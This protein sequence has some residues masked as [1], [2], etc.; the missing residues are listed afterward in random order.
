MNNNR[1]Q[2]ILLSSGTNEVEFLL[3]KLGNQRYGINVSKVCTIQV[4]ERD[5][6]FP[7]PNQLKEV[8][9]VCIF[10]D[11]TISIIDLALCVAA[12]SD[13]ESKR[14]LL[15]VAE[16]NK[17]ITGFVVDEV[18]RIERFSWTQFEPISETTCNNDVSSV[19]GTVKVN[20]EL[21]IILD[22]ETVVA[23][24]N[25]T[26]SIEHYE[27]NIEK[28]IVDRNSLKIAHIDDS[29]M[30]Q[31]FLAKA[32]DSAGFSSLKQFNN[33]EDAVKFLSSNKDVDLIICDIE[34]PRM[35]G[36]S[37]CK[38]IRK[39]PDFE[40]V[41]I[42]FFSSLITEQM[43]V[44]CKNVGGTASFSK[45]QVDELVKEIDRYVEPASKD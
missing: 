14:R 29:V 36:L 13:S 7:M 17:R 28:S 42:I 1:N 32:L 4:F 16:F 39:N 45:P 26:M 40:K 37:F 34:M 12:N 8:I 31:K 24:L 6:V 3:L 10:R 33:G 5:K 30:I 23:K 41:P 21:I 9:G 2:E 27:P 19:L 20:N 35:D 25:P 11:K 18:D 38:N 43:A 44:K 15:V 22:L